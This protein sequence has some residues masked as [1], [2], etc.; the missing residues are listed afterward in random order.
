[1]K[2]VITIVAVFSIVSVW[3]ANCALLKLQREQPGV[4]AG[5]GVVRVDWWFRC[6]IGVFKLA[7]SPA[8]TQI[9][10]RMRVVFVCASISVVIAMLASI[11]LMLFPEIWTD[12]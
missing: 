12:W 4:L 11:S 8:K 1:M 7:F 10:R 6:V 5:V 9:P 2:T 3:Q